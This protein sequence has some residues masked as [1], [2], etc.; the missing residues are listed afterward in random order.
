VISQC[1]CHLSANVLPTSGWLRLSFV[2]I[3]LWRHALKVSSTPGQD[4]AIR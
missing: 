4:L 1:L 3:V 2:K